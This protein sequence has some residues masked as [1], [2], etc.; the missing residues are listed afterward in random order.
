MSEPAS[1]TGSTTPSTTSS[2]TSSA[3]LLRSFS[4][5]S[6]AAARNL[7]QCDFRHPRP[8]IGEGDE[9]EQ[10]HV[11]GGGGA[12]IVGFRHRILHQ[13]CGGLLQMAERRAHWRDIGLHRLLKAVVLGKGGD[14]VEERNHRAA[15]VAR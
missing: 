7:V 13:P 11:I 5:F 6:G 2:T 3:R 9:A 10:L 15:A 12:G 8:N 14:F 1:P 4:A